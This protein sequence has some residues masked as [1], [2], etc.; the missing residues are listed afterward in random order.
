MLSQAGDAELTDCGASRWQGDVITL[1]S[2][3]HSSNAMRLLQGRIARYFGSRPLT[4]SNA[5]TA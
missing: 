2:V 4:I 1:G 5:K 3:L